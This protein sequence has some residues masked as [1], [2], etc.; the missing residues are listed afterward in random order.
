MNAVTYDNLDSFFTVQ[1]SGDDHNSVAEELGSER[2]H[3]EDA[4]RAVAE[5]V[6][7]F[8]LGS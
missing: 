7:V 1:S 3:E 8:S 6:G 4:A 5:T 2:E